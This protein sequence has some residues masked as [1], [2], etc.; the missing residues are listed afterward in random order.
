M[1]RIWTIDTCMCVLVCVY[2]YACAVLQIVCL[3]LSAVRL[4]DGHW[5]AWLSPSAFPFT[6]AP[7]PPTS[8][9]RCLHVLVAT[10]GRAVH[11][12]CASSIECDA[13]HWGLCLLDRTC[14]GLCA[15][16]GLL[17]LAQGTPAAVLQ[18]LLA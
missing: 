4:R 12:C 15:C 8:S 9:L 13:V 18:Q 16:C 3:L 11:H 5:R 10:I 2:L 7:P 1:F 6:H 17:W 14:M